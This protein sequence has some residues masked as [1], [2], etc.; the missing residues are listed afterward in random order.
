M[1]GLFVLMIFGVLF[2]ALLFAFAAVA[3]VVKLAV[4]IILLPLLLL[5][6]LI[7]GVTFLV[8]GPVLFILGL[9]ACAALLFA[10]AVPLLPLL[11]VVGLVW[12]IVRS[13]RRRVVVV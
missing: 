10:L 5:K 12:L 4:R 6:W 3:L 8:V 1:I 7:A 9:I 11:F 13:Q 2:A